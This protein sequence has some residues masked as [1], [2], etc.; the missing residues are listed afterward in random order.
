MR[1][2]RATPFSAISVVCAGR[3]PLHIHTQQPL[4]LPLFRA[5]VIVGTL[6]RETGGRTGQGVCGE[7]WS[8]WSIVCWRLCLL[9]GAPSCFQGQGGGGGGGAGGMGMLN[10]S[11]RVGCARAL[12][13]CTR[14]G[15]GLMEARGSSI[16]HWRVPKDP[17]GMA[18]RVF[19]VGREGRVLC[20]NIPPSF[21]ETRFS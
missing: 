17:L 21:K 13:A 15:E 11:P 12:G 6:R 18:Q 5:R 2:W 4:G 9:P 3:P 7:G 14:L 8:C 19:G 20:V 1:L 16:S 10:L